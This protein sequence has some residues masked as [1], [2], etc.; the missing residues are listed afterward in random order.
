MVPYQRHEGESDEQLLLRMARNKDKDGNTW[1]D[2]ADEMNRIT[3][4]EY[5]ESAYRKQFSSFN[6]MFEANQNKL[7]GEEYAQEIGVLKRELERAKIQLRDERNSWQKQNYIDARVEQ[8]LDFMGEALEKIGRIDFKGESSVIPHSDTDILC[9]LSDMHI[10]QTFSTPFG[11]YNTDI[12]RQRLAKYYRAVADLSHQYKAE[13]LYVV[14]LG[15]DI[16]GSIHKSIQVTNRENVIEQVKMASEMIAS[17]A[18]DLSS[19]FR[20]VYL[21]GVSG[22]HSRIDKKEDAL[23]DERLDHLVL[24]IVGRLLSSSPNITVEEPNIETGIAKIG[25]RGHEYTAVHGDYDQMTDAG[26]GKLAMMLGY[27]PEHLLLGHMHYCELTERNGVKIIRGGSLAGSGDQFTVERRM[28]GGPK[29]MACV[30][31][32]KGLIGAFPIALG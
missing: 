20:H 11:V 28:S 24:W 22:N 1:Q 5:G 31:G 16:S 17:F 7:V 3:G 4:H 25:I 15:D 23:H 21:T 12:A 29:Q 26:I 30:V 32:D 13:N 8:K 6:K 14:V 2:I 27:I 10:G 19:E 9:L 18:A